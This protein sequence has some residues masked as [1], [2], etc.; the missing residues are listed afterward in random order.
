MTA[1]CVTGCWYP[2]EEKPYSGFRNIV[3]SAHCASGLEAPDVDAGVARFEIPRP[4]PVLYIIPLPEKNHYTKKFYT[5]MRYC[6]MG[7]YS[8][9][10]SLHNETGTNCLMCESCFSGGPTDAQLLLLIWRGDVSRSGHVRVVC[11]QMKGIRSAS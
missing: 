11:F 1:G 4:P 7:A 6:E 8:R 9:T 3:L 10:R 2:R 5:K